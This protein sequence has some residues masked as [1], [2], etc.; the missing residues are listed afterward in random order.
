ML[1][2]SPYPGVSQSL[3]VFQSNIGLVFFWLFGLLS[4]AFCQLTGF[5]RFLVS[6]PFFGLFVVFRHGLG[7][8][9]DVCNSCVGV[10]DEL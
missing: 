4:L 3:V 2:F 5:C 8:C 1:G 10:G 9:E 7:V 6:H